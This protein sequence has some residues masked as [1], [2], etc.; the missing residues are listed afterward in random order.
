MHFYKSPQ[1]LDIQSV[2]VIFDSTSK[3]FEQ[4]RD[5]ERDQ[6]LSQIVTRYIFMTALM[7]VS[8]M[9]RLLKG[10]FATYLDQ[11]RGSTLYQTILIFLQSCSIEKTDLPERAATITEQ[12][13]KSERIFKNADGSIDTA[14]R[15]RN[16]L[17]A[18]PLYDVIKWWREEFVEQRRD[19]E[20]GQSGLASGML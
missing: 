3:V 16:R 6:R 20:P 11:A 5:L 7:G 12:I 18:S 1:T 4:I 9:V 10:P 8:F 15:V 2:I 13:W 17:S 19:I 14:L